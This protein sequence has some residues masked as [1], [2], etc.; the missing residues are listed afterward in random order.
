MRPR[1]RVSDT[2]LYTFS[3]LRVRTRAATNS[4]K[5]IYG[6]QKKKLALF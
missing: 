1:L 4:E 3:R 5:K 6:K 2:R